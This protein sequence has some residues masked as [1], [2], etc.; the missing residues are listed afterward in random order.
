MYA[1]NNYYYFIKQNNTYTYSLKLCNISK[2]DDYYSHEDL[3]EDGIVFEDNVLYCKHVHSYYN[4][5]YL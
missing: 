1:L 2:D 5:N 3:E 4:C